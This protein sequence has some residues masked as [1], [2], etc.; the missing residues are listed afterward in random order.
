M[1]TDLYLNIS[2]Y[3]LEL[4]FMPKACIPLGYEKNF[5]KEEVEMFGTQEL[6][7]SV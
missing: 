1:L 5:M 4:H 3:V 2:K 7:S 6:E